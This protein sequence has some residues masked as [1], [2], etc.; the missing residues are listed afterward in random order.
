[1]QEKAKVR[2]IL[3]YLT[4]EALWSAGQ[5]LTIRTFG[6]WQHANL[7]LLCLLCLALAML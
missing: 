5:N 3:K 6:L 7:L 2:V 1:M 4:L